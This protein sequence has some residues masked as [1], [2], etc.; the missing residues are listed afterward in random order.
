MNLVR[1]KA[2]VALAA[3]LQMSIHYNPAAISLTLTEQSPLAGP[4]LFQW[5][6][7]PA[8]KWRL[9]PEGQLV[10]KLS[11]NEWRSGL[12]FAYGVIGELER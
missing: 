6:Q 2:T 9:T 5:V 3:G 4:T 7:R 1:E 11:E 10:R 8:S 12:G